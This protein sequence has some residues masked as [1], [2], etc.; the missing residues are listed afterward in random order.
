M[1]KFLKKL[2]VTNI[3]NLTKYQIDKLEV[4]DVVAKKTNGMYHHYIVSYKENNVGIC[5]TYTDASVVETVSYDYVEGNWVY[6]S[7]DVLTPA[8]KSYVDTLMSGALK[9][10]IVETLPTENIDTNTIYMVLDETASSGNVYNEYLYINNAW[11]LIGT[12]AT[13][14]GLLSEIVDNNGNA[15]FIEGNGTPATIEGLTYLYNKWSLSGTHLMIVL[16]FANNTDT[17]ISIFNTTLCSA[18]LPNYIAN[19]IVSIESNIVSRVKFTDLTMSN[20]F[21]ATLEKNNNQ[22][23]IFASSETVKTGRTYRLQF[24]LLIDT[25]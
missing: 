25:E 6:N 21:T 8:S 10:A 20:N 2:E 18:S 14:G 19:K 12:T 13:S 15:R 1:R 7:T 16:V 3:T 4:G 22:I 17:D 11:E 9:R 5:L 23:S 24:D